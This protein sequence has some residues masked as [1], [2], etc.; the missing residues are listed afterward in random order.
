[1]LIGIEEKLSITVS[2]SSTNFSYGWK[3]YQEA[4]FSNNREKNTSGR[5]VVALAF[6][7]SKLHAY[8]PVVTTCC[9]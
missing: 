3:R 7:E 8:S 5:R 2:T 6:N 1:M 9:L 4:Y